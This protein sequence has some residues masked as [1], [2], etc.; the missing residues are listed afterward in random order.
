MAI[1][2]HDYLCLDKIG[3]KASSKVFPLWVYFHLILILDLLIAKKVIC[4]E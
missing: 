1:Q 2:D 4:Q 3:E